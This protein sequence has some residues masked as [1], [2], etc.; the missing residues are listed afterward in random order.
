LIGE[1]SAPSSREREQLLK[2]QGAADLAWEISRILAVQSD[3]YPFIAAQYTDAQS[4]YATM[5]EMLED[6]FYTTDFDD[7]VIYPVSLDLW[8]EMSSQVTESLVTLRNVSTKA[9]REYLDGLIQDTAVT[10]T[11]RALIFSAALLLCGYSF[12]IIVRRVIRP[13]NAM[14]AALLGTSRGEVVTFDVSED[15]RDEI[16]KLGHVLQ[17]GRYQTHVGSTRP[18]REPLARGCRQCRRRL[19]Q[20]RLKRPDHGLQSG[21]RASIWL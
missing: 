2:G 17:R 6:V 14:I 8:F 10:I 20:L 12:W 7:Q 5:H 11:I 21:L 9:T 3:L 19:D 4:H 15:R 13:I 1:S 18:Q 16:G